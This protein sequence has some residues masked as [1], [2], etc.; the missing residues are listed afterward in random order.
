MTQI[1][2]HTTLKLD[3]LTYTKPE[4][5]GNH[6]YSQIYHGDNKPVYIQTPLLG[7]GIPGSNL[8]SKNSLLQL[9]IDG[10]DFG[11]YDFFLKLDDHNV[12]QT[13]SMSKEW[14]GKELPVNVIDDMYRRGTKPFEKGSNPSL[15][16]KIPFTK[17][18]CECICFNKEKQS[19]EIADIAEDSELVCI[20]HIKG[21]KFLK[22]EYYCD[23]YITQ[24]KVNE[25]RVNK[26]FFDECLIEDE[27]VKDSKEDEKEDEKNDSELD[28]VKEE[29]LEKDRLEK[30]EKERLEK[31]EKEKK[32][33]EEK[34][35]ELTLKEKEHEI[36]SQTLNNLA[37]EIQTLRK[38]L[39][40]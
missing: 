11:I 5:Q 33:K 35:S 14:F 38:E 26:S 27:V 16:F 4:K 20:V 2:K 30:V 1:F 39:E 24:I 10:D 34:Q 19:V 3:D 37:D 8:N 28:K 15:D 22:K 36:L 17:D 18:K 12:D 21:L 29:E 6:Y 13:F 32:D 7:C 25:V 9:K 40:S 23:C 31:E